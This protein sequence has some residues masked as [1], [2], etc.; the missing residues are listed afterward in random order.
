[1][2]TTPAAQLAAAYRQCKLPA[3][4]QQGLADFL[5]R[6][7]HRSVAEL[8][9]GVPRW[10]EDPAYLFGILAGYLQIGALTETPDQQFQHMAQAAEALVTELTRRAQ[11]RS[12][13]RGLLAGFFLRRA[14]ALGG[15]REMPRFCLALLLADLRR[16]L[17]P[18]GAELAQRGC[19]MVADDIFFLTLPEVRDALDGM[20]FRVTV[21][22]RRALFTQESLR[23][24][25]PLVLLS[26]G[27]TP[28]TEPDALASTGATLRG[29][30]AAPGHTT[31]AARVVYDPHD[32]A[33]MPGE[34]LVA[35]VTDPGWTP[36]FLTAG[37]LVMEFGGPMAHGAIVAREYGIPAVVGVTGATER[38]PNG[39]RITVDGSTGTIVIEPASDG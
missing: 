6:Y 16:L 39:S 10:S 29:L 19:L 33:L 2:R 15:L 32:S 30:P 17:L 37:G 20:D 35:S 38:I 12:R 22:E 3:C 7:G 24:A 9:L 25:V 13:A 18:I 1:V 8:D 31:A 5:M 27:T 4:L 34:I 14:R 23:R 11:R 21:Q 26:D 36:L 28:V